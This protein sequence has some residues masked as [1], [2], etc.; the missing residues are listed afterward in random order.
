[1]PIDYSIPLRGTVATFNP[2]E[3]IG[4]MSQLHSQR[5][6]NE[7]N[8]MKMGQLAREAKT[9]DAV[10]RAFQ[11]AGGDAFKA[12]KFLRR[13]GFW[14]VSHKIETD[15]RKLKADETDAF[16]KALTQRQTALSQA[17][18]LLD[19]AKSAEGY[20]AVL[21]SA[22]DLVMSVDP[23]LA[24]QIQDEY[25]PEMVK[26]YVAWGLT[27]EQKAKR[28]SDASS[29]ARDTLLNAKT[30]LELHDGFTKSLATA[31]SALQTDEPETPKEVNGLPAQANLP[32]VSK[33]ANEWNTIMD[34][35]RSIGAAPGTLAQF[36]DY[37][38]E[39]MNV[40]KT[41]AAGK[42]P[43]VGSLGDYLYRMAE[44]KKTNVFDLTDDEVLDARKKWAAADNVPIQPPTEGSLGDIV[45]RKEKELGRKMT[46]DEIIDLKARGAEDEISAAQRATAERWYQDRVAGLSADLR[47]G[48]ITQAD[49]DKEKASVD[50][51]YRRQL[52][53][54]TPGG[55]A[56][57]PPPQGPVFG[58]PAPG[59][60]PGVNMGDLMRQGGLGG[61]PGGSPQLGGAPMPPPGG[62]GA[63]LGPPPQ[64]GTMGSVGRPMGA[65][66]PGGM[67]P[68]PRPGMGPGQA[69]P[70]PPSGV[71]PG[72]AAP[73]PQV[74]MGPGQMAPPAPPPPVVRPQAP[75]APA[76][77][78]VPDPVK[79]MFQR[80]GNRDGILKAPD[81][82]RWQMYQGK[83]VSLPKGQ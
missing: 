40:V 81:G 47:N 70:A 59:R 20:A 11:E 50:A 31:L 22:R 14:D 5:Q 8:Q 43:E 23:D 79:F 67:A 4:Q 62:G 45:R 10:S 26:R 30:A 83:I 37:S 55:P 39:N 57:S 72:Q 69:A 48:L 74:G 17:A 15:W 21:P 41:M 3:Q 27:E 71:G 49:F 33:A 65:P 36:G 58:A 9:Q 7:I 6:N 76:E 66:G 29:L 34:Q 24:G 18:Q 42:R 28:L 51:S 2:I 53:S 13:D 80:N 75:P 32:G 1:M 68:T 73:A 60:T 54:P 63:P 19:A 61:R 82:S 38:P 52:A 44:D 77:D 16:G 46:A 78:P 64:A 25:D 35:F 56:Y 12:S